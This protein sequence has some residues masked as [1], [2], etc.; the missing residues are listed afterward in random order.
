L[1]EPINLLL[2]AVGCPGGPAIIKSLRQDSAIR[3]V[4]TDM[5]GDVPSRYLADGF[6][7]VPAGRSAEYIDEMLKLVAS[8][9]IDVILP[10][11]TFEL[12]ALA[13]HKELFRQKGCQVCVSDYDALAIANDRRKLYNAFAGEGFVPQ[14]RVPTDWRD[15]EAKMEELGFPG[16][17]VVIKPFVSHGSIGLRVIDSQLDLFDLYSN[18]KPNSTL[19]SQSILRETFKDK[20]LDNLILSEYLPGREYGVD[21]LLDPET[22]KVISGLVR[23]N[24]DVE[25]SGVSRAELVENDEL[26]ATA[27]YV[28]EKLGLSYAINIDFKLDDKNKPKI[29]E[30]NPRL[31][32]TSYLATAAGL[33]LP[34]LS[35]YL[36]LG[37]EVGSA[38]LKR[39]LRLYAY[40]G[41]IVVN[42]N[43]EIEDTA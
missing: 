17:R 20:P 25:L 7:Q 24:G 6:H 41:F 42:D 22:H 27:K 13:R 8:E 31:P 5:R 10:L 33:N 2:T 19:V 40:R 37:R 28:A 15:L 18:L 9:G 16:K 32:A 26:F 11:A 14:F 1:N 34:L 3:I 39:G 23:D 38:R 29:I 12:E 4:G 36:A 35:V 43:G 30:V 21:L